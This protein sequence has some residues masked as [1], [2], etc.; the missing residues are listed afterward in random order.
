MVDFAQIPTANALMSELQ[1]VSAGLDNLEKGGRIIGMQ[2]AMAD[3]PEG[4]VPSVYVSTEGIDYPP[5][6]IEAIKAALT[7]RRTAVA[8]ELADMGVTGAPGK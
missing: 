5:Q 8:K 1:R 2:I 6:M 7:A 4:S 3:P